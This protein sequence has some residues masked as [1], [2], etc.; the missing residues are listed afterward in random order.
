LPKG[1]CI[2]WLL[3]PIVSQLGL[4]LP[5]YIEIGIIVEPTYQLLEIALRAPPDVAA[6]S[7]FAVLL[8]V[9]RRIIDVAER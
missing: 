5:V 2:N 9:R 4:R 6:V 3:L 7:D 1:N 8:A